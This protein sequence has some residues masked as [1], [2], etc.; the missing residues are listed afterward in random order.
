MSVL[1]LGFGVLVTRPVQQA[2]VLCGLIEEAGGK[3]IRLPLLEIESVQADDPG[4]NRLKTL[5][6]M[7]WLV[8]TSANAV[9]CAFALLGPQWLTCKPPNIAAIGQATAKALLS[10]GIAVDIRPEPP[11]NSESLLAM[12][13]WL[14]VNGHSFVIV[15]GVGGREL[16]AETLRARGGKVSYA[17]VYR[18]FAPDLD[19]SG[20]MDNWKKGHIAVSILTS[21]EALATLWHQMPDNQRGLLIDTPMV[22]IGERVASQAR[23][24]GVRDVIVS[25]AGDADLFYAVL[26]IAQDINQKHQLRG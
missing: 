25:E 10:N 6:G 26:R 15:R 1:P 17:E 16:L 23:E 4:P 7:D 12:P 11:F 9:R 14:K 20:L 19:L 18:R 13:E 22:V 2:H 5:E 24:L 21:G 8:F 3:A